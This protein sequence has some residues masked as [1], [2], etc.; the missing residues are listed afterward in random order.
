MFGRN[1][2]GCWGFEM[3]GPKVANYVEVTS[4]IVNLTVRSS[5]IDC[6]VIIINQQLTGLF[7]S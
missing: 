2:I 6:Q 5:P 7:K 1:G 3:K 4:I